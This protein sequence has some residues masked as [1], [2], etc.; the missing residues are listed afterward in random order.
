[1]AT[2][3]GQGLQV[4]LIVFV[5]LTVILG[6]TS[7]LMY[8]NYDEQYQGRQTA[9]TNLGT[10]K[11]AQG[12]TLDKLNTLR[13]TI[14]LPPKN[15]ADNTQWQQYSGEVADHI[16]LYVGEKAPQTY[17]MAIQNLN[18]QLA[19]EQTTRK[20]LQDNK[21]ELQKQVMALQAEKNAAVAAA[22]EA[23]TASE[24]SRREQD[25]EYKKRLAAK[26][27]ALEQSDQ[28]AKSID[29]KHEQAVR[30]TATL[31]TE[32]QQII[33]QQEDLIANQALQL[34]DLKT[35][36]FAQVDAKIR[37]V[38]QPGR[39]V[40]LNVGSKDFV[41]TRV[42]FAVYGLD[43][44]GK[45]KKLPKGAVEV[46]K[47]IG[48]GQSEARITR[49]E[50]LM[51]P[52]QPGD[53]V[54]TPL[55]HPGEP[56]RFALVGVIDLDGDGKDDR[57]LVRS[58]IRLAGGSVDEEILADGSK[59]GSGMTVKTNWLVLGDEPTVKEVT[60]ATKGNLA[61]TSPAIAGRSEILKRA[62]EY[63]V[64]VLNVSEF[65]DMVGYV[66]RFQIVRPG[67]LPTARRPLGGVRAPTARS[68]P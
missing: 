67:Q 22:D 8:R 38:D 30:D 27:V 41:P 6:V 51:D 34:R 10:A 52:I 20:K 54:D 45:P 15:L 64:T 63:A 29:Q 56:Q 66:P 55:W 50:N 58:M 2:S 68:Y 62:R 19:G 61:D 9:E 33:T 5:I 25:N 49:Q 65:R 4:A 48:E 57:E 16:K 42:T 59:A 17:A 14:G 53:V 40:Y 26:D 36:S 31:R 39:A 18:E 7:F 13:D 60:E 35:T 28:Q 23:R 32:T 37:K 21:D 44:D 12:E 3:Q 1:M 47:V 46:T 43:R 11:K 24:N